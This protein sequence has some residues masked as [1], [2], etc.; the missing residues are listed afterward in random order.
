MAEADAVAAAA[1]AA[2]EAAA[3]AALSAGATAVVANTAAVVAKAAAEAAAAAAPPPSAAAMATE[4]A[5][6][7]AEADAVAAEAE[8]AAEADAVA[9]YPST[10]CHQLDKGAR[11]GEFLAGVVAYSA[12]MPGAKHKA[13]RPPFAPRAEAVAAAAEAAAEA[14]ESL[15]PSTNCH[16]LDRGAR[17]GESLVLAGVAYSANMPGAKHKARH[18]P[19]APRA[20]APTGAAQ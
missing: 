13:R 19:F 20:E 9:A 6:V 4:A 3:A 1:E 15:Y 11:A 2:A 14:T 16:Q 18:P 7:M 12:K 17:A 8:A 10:N 5:A